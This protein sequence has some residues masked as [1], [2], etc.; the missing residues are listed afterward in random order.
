MARASWKTPKSNKK[1][2]VNIARLGGYYDLKYFKT[3]DYF[4]T[5]TPLIR[6]YLIEHGI[7]PNDVRH[8]NNFAETETIS[9][10]VEA[11]NGINSVLD[12]IEQPKQ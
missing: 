1:T 10:P 4:I 6:D 9:K 11:L 12:F 7:A 5:I 3:S 2:H 8:I